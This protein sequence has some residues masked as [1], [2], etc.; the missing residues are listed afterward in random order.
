MNDND[1]NNMFK[2][3]QEMIQ[4]NQIPDELKS[5]VANMQKSSNSANNNSKYNITYSRNDEILK[6]RLTNNNNELNVVLLYNISE[7]D[8]KY[9][10]DIDASINSS[11]SNINS[12]G[13]SSDTQIINKKYTAEVK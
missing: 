9:N 2:K 7:E 5:M 10:L 13:V 8:G 1:F 4:N 6:F 12:I 3:A 11:F